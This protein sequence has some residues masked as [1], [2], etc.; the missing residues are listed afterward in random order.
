MPEAKKISIVDWKNPKNLLLL[1]KGLTEEEIADKLGIG[2][3][4][5]FA[6]RLKRAE[7]LLPLHSWAKKKGITEITED[8]IKEFL[9][10][11]K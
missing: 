11:G 5:T 6:I 7:F 10:E 1:T 9:Q 2:R 4:H 3:E 8:V